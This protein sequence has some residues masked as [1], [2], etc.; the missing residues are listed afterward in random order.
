VPLIARKLGP[1]RLP[2]NPIAAMPR[3]C[4]TPPAQTDGA[5]LDTAIEGRHVLIVE[6]IVDSGLT[7]Q[8]P[9]RNLGARN[10]ASL[11]VC[12]L[13]T[14]PERR[15]VELPIIGFEIPDG[16]GDYRPPVKARIACA[17][18]AGPQTPWYACLPGHPLTLRAP[19]ADLGLHSANAE[20]SRR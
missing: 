15:K 14:K 11:E 10:P 13:L 6:D 4:T 17:R 12:A 9:F 18:T 2:T 19:N 3:Q 1:H 16:F 7:L 20:G 5:L 8:Y